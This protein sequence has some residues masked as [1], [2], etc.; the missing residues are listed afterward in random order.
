MGILCAFGSSS[1]RTRTMAA[2]EVG[3]KLV[4]C[5]IIL[6]WRCSSIWQCWRRGIGLVLC[7]SF[8]W[9]IR[10]NLFQYRE[11]VVVSI[12]E[13]DSVHIVEDNASRLKIFK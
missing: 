13:G 11:W 7:H 9:L 3:M 5:T 6:V 10:R 8:S 1:I 4:A 12:D 2:C